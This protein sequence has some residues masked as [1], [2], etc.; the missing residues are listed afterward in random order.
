[1]KEASLWRQ[2]R[3]PAAVAIVVLISVVGFVWLGI[4]GVVS[5]SPEQAATFGTA[6]E[7]FAGLLTATAVGIALFESTDTRRRARIER[8]CAVTAWMQLERRRDGS[9]SWTV[10]VMNA[11]GH[12]VFQ[13]IVI[14]RPR[15]GSEGPWHLCGSQLGPLLPDE[16][17]YAISHGGATFQDYVPLE[18]QFEDREGDFWRRTAHGRLR[19]LD[20]ANIAEVDCV[21]C[22]A[23]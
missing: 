23:Q 15:D 1:M 22:A 3:R 6:G 2:P 16:N 17:C 19:R 10:R 7:W 18:L 8:L 20:G 13:W 9:P 21:Y 5:W 12:P 14:P 4:D 11:T